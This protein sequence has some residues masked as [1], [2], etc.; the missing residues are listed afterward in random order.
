MTKGRKK[1]GRKRAKKK[2]AKKDRITPKRPP[3]TPGQDQ[4][5]GE[6][7]ARKITVSELIE[8][9]DLS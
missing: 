1:G 8:D 5:D 6:E 2:A 7:N 3:P 9:M 4:E